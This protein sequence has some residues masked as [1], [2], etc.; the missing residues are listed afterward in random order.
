MD[1]SG[2]LKYLCVTGG[3]AVASLLFCLE[4]GADTVTLK[5]GKELKGLVV[6]NHA[7]RVIFSTEKGEI[8]ILLKGIKNIA[9]DNP[10]QN[11]MQIGKSYEAQGKLGEA[12]AYYEKAL[13]VN[14]DYQ[15]A[16]NAA[17]GVRNRFW[18]QS[19]EGP[20]DEVEKKQIIYD[21][22]SQGRPVEDFVKKQEMAQS[23]KLENSLG[24][25]LEKRG[26]WVR[27]QSVGPRKTA[28]A[29][30]LRKNDRL[31]SIDGQ[32]LRYL[33]VSAVTKNLLSP[34]YSNF[35]LGF[36]RDCFVHRE[37][38]IKS[39]RDLGL[40][41][42]FVYDGLIVESVEQNGAADA[43]G[44]KEND[45]VTY[46]NGVSTRYMPIQKVHQL[47]LESTGEKLAFTIQ[48]TALLARK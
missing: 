43:A 18:A 5:N 28:A 24:I 30:G 10:E 12:L 35:T 19:T 8:P 31:I 15:D 45:L 3:V 40:T 22:W 39:I 27:V 41:L 13:E 37:P 26:D 44:M 14:P 34:H 11:F 48:R 2:D 33:G 23:G 32:S 46:V 4:S 29:V 20:R 16:K 38:D 47:I 6:E 25:S 7:D 17:V 1:F 42:K 36:E 9:Y 21:S